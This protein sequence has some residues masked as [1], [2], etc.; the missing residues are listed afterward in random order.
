MVKKI[1]NS[2]L[3][4]WL[5]NEPARFALLSFGLIFSVSILYVLTKE[6]FYTN[7]IE[8]PLPFLLLVFGVMIFS[9]YKLIKWL[10][11]DNM[12]RRSFIAIDNGLSFIYFA[13][14][15]TLTILIAS[16]SQDI[17][18]YTVWLQ[19]YSMILFMGA[20]FIGSLIYLYIL[21]LMV[22]NLYSVYR[23]AISMGIPKWKVIL[24]LPFTFSMFWIAG[25]LLPED[26]KIKSAITIKTKWYSRLTDWVLK[27]PINTLIS[28]LLIT[29]FM[30]L[31][32]DLY[33]SSLT[34]FF[35][36]IF[37]VWLWGTGLKKFQKSIGGAFSTFVSALNILIVVLMIGFLVFTPNKQK[38][39]MQYDAVQI[40]DKI[41]K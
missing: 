30:G 21:G 15:F 10:P 17:V 16:N 7:I 29:I 11:K 8:S 6:V 34:I 22:A 38:S 24:S 20:A 19:H 33:S 27:K 37:G 28:F 25:Y 32:F 35:T 40:T 2:K 12:D 26:K 5:F 3:L 13:I 14:F 23:R 4:S 9:V 1:T 39:F 18:F 36:I 31:F 41:I